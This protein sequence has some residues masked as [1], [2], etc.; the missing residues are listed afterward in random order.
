MTHGISGTLLLDPKVIDDPYP[1]YRELHAHAPVHVQALPGVRM[2][3][4]RMP[5]AAQ[6][7]CFRLA[8]E[9]QLQSAA[10]K[11]K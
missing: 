2:S 6:C 8:A 5:T 7:T 10:S 1:F 9:L 3:G 11:V 4:S